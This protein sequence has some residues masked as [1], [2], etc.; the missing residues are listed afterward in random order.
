MIVSEL[1]AGVLSLIVEFIQALLL[2]L[3]ILG[4]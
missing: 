1:L 4:L 2:A 3:G